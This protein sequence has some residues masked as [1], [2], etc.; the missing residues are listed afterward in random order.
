MRPPHSIQIENDKA[1][2]REGRERVSKRERESEIVFFIVCDDNVDDDDGGGGGMVNSMLACNQ[3]IYMI[4]RFCS[5]ALLH[6][7]SID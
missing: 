7:P 5:S 6:H 4:K 2:R 3:S 1:S